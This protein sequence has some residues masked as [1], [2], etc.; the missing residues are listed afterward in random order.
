MVR[1]GAAIA[2]AR[3]R[4]HVFEIRLAILSFF[5]VAATRSK[6]AV[7]VKPETYLYETTES[8]LRS[9]STSKALSLWKVLWRVNS[10]KFR[11]YCFKSAESAMNDCGFSTL[12]GKLG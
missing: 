6:S 7:Y 5:V 8:L 4:A 3:N 2:S 10:W 1:C 11:L 12:L 9:Q